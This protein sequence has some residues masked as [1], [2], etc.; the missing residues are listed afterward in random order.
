[1]NLVNI[2]MLTCLK[3]MCLESAKRLHSLHFCIVMHC[4]CFDFIC[5]EVF[6]FIDMMHIQYFDVT[7][8]QYVL[9]SCLYKCMDLSE[10]KTTFPI[11]KWPFFVEFVQF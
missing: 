11:K 9:L 1:M 4:C 3:D 8:N 10:K 5:N 6:S 7:A 2:E